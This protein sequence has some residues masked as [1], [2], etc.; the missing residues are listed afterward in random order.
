MAR[1]LSV[2]EKNESIWAANK[3]ARDEAF[4][5]RQDKINK[6]T[7]RYEDYVKT[8][9]GRPKSR[10]H[11]DI[12]T[13]KAALTAER[14]ERA[15]KRLLA[16]EE[17]YNRYLANG[18]D[19]NT[20][21]KQWERLSPI[22]RTRFQRAANE[23]KSIESGG[24][25]F[26]S[27]FLPGGREHWK[28]ASK[29]NDI[30]PPVA[31]T[32]IL[33]NRRGFNPNAPDYDAEYDPALQSTGYQSGNH[34]PP[35]ITGN[36]EAKAGVVP[37]IKALS[38]EEELMQQEVVP[39]NKKVN[40]TVKE[41]NAVYAEDLVPPPAK[42]SS[43]F[44]EDPNDMGVIPKTDAM[45][46]K[47]RE[48]GKNGVGQN[49]EESS[50]NVEKGTAK[51]AKGEDI[52]I[53]PP[54]IKGV[55]EKAS[56]LF[57]DIFSAA[58]LK[59]MTLY[60]LGGILTGGSME[61][62]FQWAGM[63][64]ME[65]Q[66]TTKN[67]EATIEAER[68]KFERDMFR[69]DKQY[70][71]D[72][73]K[74]SNLFDFSKETASILSAGRADAAK[75]IADASLLDS[76]ARARAQVLANS[77]MAKATLAAQTIKANALLGAATTKFNREQNKNN[78][79]ATGT[80]RDWAI[81]GFPGLTE[82]TSIQYD[83]GALGKKS[84]VT[85]KDPNTGE[86]KREYLTDFKAMIRKM[87]GGKISEN[88]ESVNN[89]AEQSKIIGDWSKSLREPFENL[90]DREGKIA[91]L[92]NPL[93]PEHAIASAGNYW[94]TRGYDLASYG[95]RNIAKQ[96]TILAAGD[97]AKYAA[98][99]GNEIFSID[100]FID[101]QVF[102]VEALGAGTGVWQIGDGEGPGV[103]PAK[104]IKFRDRIRRMSM[105]DSDE[106]GRDGDAN[107]KRSKN[108]FQTLWASFK[109]L[110]PDVK[111]NLDPGDDEN[112]FLVYANGILDIKVKG[113]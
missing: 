40:S 48:E 49:M 16:D 63:K 8:V 78:G 112:K 94:D 54:V 103:S 77:V 86:D 105:L 6:D 18:G 17:T 37:Q 101:K 55:F 7:K 15:S 12:E 28:E 66:Q 70:A 75:L 108:K 57:G 4:K 24:T 1:Q 82:A 58:D 64:V 71:Q 61:G 65:E 34:I 3:L 41:I 113:N 72:D 27:L 100:P 50:L 35:I 53:A 107:L 69:L 91:G 87:G 83:L 104:V 21:F 85:Y 96:A 25:S 43:P 81:E 68:L 42:P 52:N 22:G 62:S 19:E 23:K 102:S 46:K 10:Q 56:S 84:I 80:T 60:T 30:V 45:L 88:Q 13:N 73:K 11:F 97:A 29:V 14:K 110:D 79:K 106:G 59:R 39:A 74:Q 76:N 20:T 92:S 67:N 109:N 31:N 51:N 93:N 26:P 98:S 44:S 2:E 38:P 90:F 111:E 9:D 33:E 32:A 5:K 95:Q 36:G 47:E 89:R 99:T